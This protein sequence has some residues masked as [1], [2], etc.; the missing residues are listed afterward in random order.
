M[1]YSAIRSIL[2]I[3]LITP[4]LVSKKITGVFRHRLS[5]FLAYIGAITAVSILLTFW[6]FENY[7][8]GFS[9]IEQAMEYEHGEVT[10]QDTVET[11][12]SVFVY[13]D[14]TIDMMLKKNGHYYLNIPWNL[15]QKNG[16]SEKGYFVTIYKDRFEKQ[17][18]V[19]L[20]TFEGNR[21]LKNF[22]DNKGSRIEDGFVE[23]GMAYF[24][25]SF[26]YDDGS[27]YKLFNNGRDIAI[28]MFN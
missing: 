17:S 11:D 8:G 18:Y 15:T 16:I 20:T 21:M 12:T 28:K 1:L 23:D 6:P 27:D 19:V 5:L 4:L 9:S 26:A 22:T 25:G 14:K 3:L 2:A 13:S 7:F 24:F 10:I